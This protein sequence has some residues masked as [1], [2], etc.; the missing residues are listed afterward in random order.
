M[1]VERSIAVVSHSGYFWPADAFSFGDDVLWI[2]CYA[3][4]CTRRVL[5]PGAETVRSSP[6]VRTA[7]RLAQLTRFVP[8]VTGST[9]SPSVLGG[10]LWGVTSPPGPSSSRLVQTV[11]RLANVTRLFSV[12]TGSRSSVMLLGVMDGARDTSVVGCTGLGILER[13]V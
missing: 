2:F 11:K 4:R 5:P 10:A 13:T 6:V 12:T 7:R 1:F 9:S 8:V 3:L